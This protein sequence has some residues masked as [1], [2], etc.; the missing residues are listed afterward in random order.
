MAEVNNLVEQKL[1]LNILTSILDLENKERK[2]R[3]QKG[4]QAA[5]KAGKY[6]GRKTVITKKLIDQIKGLNKINF[7]FLQILI[8]LVA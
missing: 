1:I 4:I 8:F 2:E 6:K 7:L 3:Q 5:R